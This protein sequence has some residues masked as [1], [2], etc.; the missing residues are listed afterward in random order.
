[1][2][3]ALTVF[4]CYINQLTGSIP[5]LSS[6]TALTQFQCHN[7]QLTGIAVDFGVP[8]KTFIF[9]ALNNQLTEVAINGIL[10]AFDRDVTVSGGKIIIN[11]AGNAAPTG[12]GLT[13]KT[14]M[15]AKGWTVSTN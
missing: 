3:P 9:N 11:G 8:N 2:N 13:A 4:Y 7:N 1:S 14:N 12:A 5:D 15:I 10:T 6:N